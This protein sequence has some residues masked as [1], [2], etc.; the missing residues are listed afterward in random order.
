VC[1]RAWLLASVGGDGK[2]ET[3]LVAVGFVVAHFDEV[4]DRLRR[5]G[6]D[7]LTRVGR[8]GIDGGCFE[9]AHDEKGTVESIDATRPCPFEFV[10]LR[11]FVAQE[12]RAG[13][14]TSMIY[15]AKHGG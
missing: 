10:T 3:E 13:L 6:D 14:V 2:P 5:D 8:V 1:S 15:G 9:R 11:D 7:R 12:V 4:L